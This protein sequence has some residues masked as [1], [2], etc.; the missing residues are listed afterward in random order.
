MAVSDLMMV[1][2]FLR[3]GEGRQRSPFGPSSLL[4]ARHTP[5]LWLSVSSTSEAERD[6]SLDGGSGPWVPVGIVLGVV[7]LGLGA[8]AAYRA[9]SRRVPAEPPPRDDRAE[10]CERQEREQLQEIA[11]EFQNPIAIQT[12]ESLAQLSDMELGEVGEDE[13]L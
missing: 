4:A 6:S 5:T 7:V 11:F 9:V 2:D 1:S 13:R 8:F 10:G 12:M 3:S